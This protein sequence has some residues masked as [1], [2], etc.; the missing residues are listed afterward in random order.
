MKRV[1]LTLLVKLTYATLQAIAHRLER[2]ALP[3][4]TVIDVQAEPS[5]V[6][7]PALPANAPASVAGDRHTLVQ[8]LLDEAWAQGLR[9]YPQ[10]IKYIELQTGTACSRRAIA[11]WKKA[12]GLMDVDAA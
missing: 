1:L 10:L 12:R 8:G 3:A 9:T 2:A 5:P 4:A 11:N 7:L 6:A